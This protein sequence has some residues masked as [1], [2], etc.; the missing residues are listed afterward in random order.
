MRLWRYFTAVFF[1]DRE[2]SEKNNNNNKNKR[3]T[4]WLRVAGGAGPFA[5]AAAARLTAY[6]AP[7]SGESPAVATQRA[8]AAASPSNQFSN[9]SSLLQNAKNRKKMRPNSVPISPRP[10]PQRSLVS[11]T[12]YGIMD[13]I[14]ICIVFLFN[15]T[16]K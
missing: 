6:G 3:R 9:E 4:T 16:F 13:H 2:T 14:T 11:R 10:S 12:V 15:R 7:T 8:T 1:S 5:P